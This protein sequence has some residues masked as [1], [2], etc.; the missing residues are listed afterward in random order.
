MI[1][2]AERKVSNG[3][4]NG[5]WT[6]TRIVGEKGDRGDSGLTGGHYEFRYNNFKPSEQASAPTKP[7]N[8]SNGTTGGWTTSQETL[9]ETQI[10]DGYATWMTQ[11]YQNEA[12][13]YDTWTDP[14][15]IT[16]ANGYDG[17][18]GS[19]IEFVYTRNNTGETPSAPPTTQQ[20]DWH[21]TL[22]EGTAN[23]ITW[24]DNPQGVLEDM[25]YEYVS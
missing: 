5:D 14:I 21:G 13:T 2:R 3:E 12:S 16:G 22:Y 19:E 1:W 10:K 11:C 7:S 8:G 24:T 17:A 20:E 15:R 25:M 9:T 18:D 4:Y 6:I 23:E